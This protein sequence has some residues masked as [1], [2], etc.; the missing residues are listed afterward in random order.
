M[1]KSIGNE[2]CPAESG[3]KR[4]KCQVGSF[5]P[6]SSSVRVAINNSILTLR[7]RRAVHDLQSAL[8]REIA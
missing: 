4:G 6:S 1:D 5:D 8:Y 7:S 3:G 2:P